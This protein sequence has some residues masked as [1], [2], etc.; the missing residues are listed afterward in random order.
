MRSWPCSAPACL[1][2]AAGKTWPRWSVVAARHESAR[3]R[4]APAGG[5]QI[6][7][8]SRDAGGPNTCVGSCRTSGQGGGP[9][10]CCT[11]PSKGEN[12]TSMHS[13]LVGEEGRPCM[14]V[15]VPQCQCQYQSQRQTA[16]PRSYDCERED[17][18]RQGVAGIRFGTSPLR[19]GSRC[20][21]H[22][23]APCTMI[24]PP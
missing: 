20:K 1:V 13:V 7:A 9:V 24:H 12:N 11:T 18:I 15:S 17:R 3:S 10:W 16:R 4:Q 22:L 8:V 6:V 23:L 5:G 19:A 21:P 14:C 2:L